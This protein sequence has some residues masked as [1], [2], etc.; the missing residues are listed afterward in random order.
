MIE[1]GGYYRDDPVEA[2]GMDILVSSNDVNA[3]RFFPDQINYGQLG[4]KRIYSMSHNINK[5]KAAISPV[6]TAKHT[7]VD[8]ALIFGFVAILGSQ[9]VAGKNNNDLGNPDA[10]LSHSTPTV[11]SITNSMGLSPEAKPVYV[12]AP[13]P[14]E[15]FRQQ[16]PTPPANY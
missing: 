14:T 1:S 10:N 9:I 13:T 12:V 4:K 3:D 6:R 7:L 11:E 16:T 5:P 2:F 15:V 8:T